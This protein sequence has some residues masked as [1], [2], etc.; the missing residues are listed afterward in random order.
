MSSNL[1]PL[2]YSITITTT[3]RLLT[4]FPATTNILSRQ[5]KAA[6]GALHHASSVSRCLTSFFS[7]FSIISLPL[8]VSQTRWGASSTMSQSSRFR[9]R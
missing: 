3:C 5:I 8:K 1:V 6:S 7:L 4:A 9:V 2:L